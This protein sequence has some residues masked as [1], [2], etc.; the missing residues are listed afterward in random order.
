MAGI[1]FSYRTGEVV[2]LKES[3][4]LSYIGAGYATL[5]EDRENATLYPAAEYRT[6]D[7]MPESVVEE[8][9][10]PEVV[11]D[12]LPAVSEE[13]EQPKAAKPKK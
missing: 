3:T 12:E 4:A 6:E 13:I 5:V 8:L 7:E 11:A 1:G 2:D 10:A 9:P